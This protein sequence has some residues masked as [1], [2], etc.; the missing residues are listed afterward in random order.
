MKR[1]KTTAQMNEMTPWSKA[2]GRRC[3]ARDPTLRPFGVAGPKKIHRV[4]CAFVH[5]PREPSAS[6]YGPRERLR[7]TRA[8]CSV[9]EPT[10]G[11]GGGGARVPKSG[12][13][14]FARNSVWTARSRESCRA[15]KRIGP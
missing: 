12:F 3:I 9:Q 2:G 4:G 14:Q 10:Y 1:P 7:P 13:A 11:A 6:A 8:P 15:I 5:L